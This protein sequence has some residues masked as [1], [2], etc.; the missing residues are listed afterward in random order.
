MSAEVAAFSEMVVQ[1]ATTFTE[2]GT[3]GNI[4]LVDM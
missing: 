3:A 1:R 2:L 4:Y